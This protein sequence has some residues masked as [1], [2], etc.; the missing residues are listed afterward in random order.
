MDRSRFWE[1]IDVSRKRGNGNQ[2]AQFDALE[3]QLRA[4]PAEEVAGFH[5]HFHECL[6]RADCNEIYG[7]AAV[8]DGFWLT[9]DLFTYFLEWLIAQGETVFENALRNAES[10]ADVVEKGQLCDFEGFG[11]VAARVWQERTGLSAEHVPGPAATGAKAPDN[12]AW[13]NDDDLKQRFPRLWAKF[14]H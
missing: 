12:P 1:I 5:A 11:Y 9:D 6:S 3:E 4:L 2:N 7:A 13:K 10:L 8:I 14:L